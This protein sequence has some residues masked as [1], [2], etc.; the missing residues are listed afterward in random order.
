MGKT[1]TNGQ[2]SMA[3]LNN[4]M[5]DTF[6]VPKADLVCSY[7]MLYHSIGKFIFRLTINPQIT[8]HTH[9]NYLP[10]VM[11]HIKPVYST[12]KEIEFHPYNTYNIHIPSY[13]Y[14]ILQNNIFRITHSDKYV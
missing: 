9:T 3:M 6:V 5:V 1:S 2:F 12:I 4:Q 13:T 10:K 14:H 8:K 11:T 7:I